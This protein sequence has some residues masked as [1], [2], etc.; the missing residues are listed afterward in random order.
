MK[1]LFVL[2]RLEEGGA[3][4]Q[5]LDLAVG[6]M[7]NGIAC[8]AV[9]M[10]SEAGLSN[11]RGVE[12]IGLGS[13]TSATSFPL[14]CLRLWNVCRRDR[15]DLVHSHAEVPNIASRLVCRWLGLPHV[16][17]AH[18][19]FP[20]NWRRNLGM[21]LGR[22]TSFLTH[23]YFAVSEAVGRMLREELHIPPDRIRV[24]PNWPPRHSE[25]HDADPMPVRGFPTLLNVARIHKQ[26]RQDLLIEAFREVR[27]R[28]PQAV[29]W[30]AG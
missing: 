18:C 28:F 17:T 5:A 20:W 26:K 25:L 9:G 7:A 6:L 11:H 29:L 8:R 3:Q 21:G 23:R 4:I 22:R 19:E 14:A 10:Y 2:D 16:V 12:T 24:I 15:P 1:V 27:R 13:S 30:I